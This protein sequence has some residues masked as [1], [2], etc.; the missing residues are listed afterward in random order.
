MD[1]PS[2]CRKVRR[3][4]ARL[5]HAGEWMAEGIQTLNELGGDG[6]L[7]PPT[8]NAAQRT[9]LTYIEKAYV[10]VGA[11]DPSLDAA[12]ALSELCGSAAVYDSGRT[13]IAPYA[14]DRVS[15]PAP[16]SLPMDMF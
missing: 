8:A 9:L 13:D 10:D 6:R 7:P 4:C 11:P 15:W 12:G 5:S 2:G 3:R 14:K 16:E 1:G